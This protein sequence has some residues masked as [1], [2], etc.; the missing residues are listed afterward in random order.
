MSSRG[1]AYCASAPL[2]ADDGSVYAVVAGPS[3]SAASGLA[4]A[5]T[6]TSVSSGA[7]LWSRPLGDVPLYAPDPP[8][9]A[10]SRSYADVLAG[11]TPFSVAAAPLQRLLLKYDAGALADGG[12]ALAAPLPLPPS[13]RGLALTVGSGLSQPSLAAAASSSLTPV[14]EVSL[15]CA[16]DGAWSYGSWAPLALALLISIAATRCA[17]LLWAS[18]RIREYSWPPK[19][20]LLL[21]W[22]A[23]AGADENG[24]L[25]SPELAAATAS[26]SPPGGGREWLAARGLAPPLSRTSLE[27]GGAVASNS[28][29]APPLSLG[30]PVASGTGTAAIVSGPPLSTAT[31]PRS[32]PASKG[33]STSSRPRTHPRTV[34]GPASA[35]VRPA[36][37]D[38]K[39]IMSLE[40]DEEDEEEEGEGGAESRVLTPRQLRRGTRF[41]VACNPPSAAELAHDADADIDALCQIRT[42]LLCLPMRRARPANACRLRTGTPWVCAS[43]LHLGLVTAALVFAAIV[44]ASWRRCSR[45]G[46]P[47]PHPRTPPPLAPRPLPLPLHN[48]SLLSI[49]SPRPAPPR[50]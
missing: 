24:T 16:W 7:P 45:W 11:L 8:A 1:V 6:A 31:G 10:A 19:R 28:G 30:P 2:V 23:L 12:A 35:A 41:W 14:I 48:G 17:G 32:S 15:S 44:R 18:I 5:L 50:S 43:L 25:K 39:R 42:H 36:A 13:R 37:L 40:E 49:D 34:R 27:E 9:A 46:D 4:F 22:A 47:P 33:P 38:I 26:G 20:P 21:R 29:L 3:P